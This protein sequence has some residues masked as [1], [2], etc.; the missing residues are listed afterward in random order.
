[1]ALALA[2]PTRLWLGGVISRQR[3][4]PLIT[5]LVQRVRAC[6]AT[7]AILVC[8]DG[9]ASYVTAFLKVFRQPIHTG[10]RGVRAWS[11]RRLPVRPGRQACG[12]AARHRGHPPGPARHPG[13]HRG[14]PDGDRHRHRHQHRLHRAAQRHLPRPPRAAH[15]TGSGD[16]PHRGGPHRRHVAGRHRLQ[17]LLAPRQPAP[18]RSR[19][20]SSEVAPPHPS[21]GGRAHRPPLDPGRA[22]PIP[23]PLTSL[24]PTQTTRPSAQ[25]SA[26][27]SSGM[28]TVPWGATVQR[29]RR[30]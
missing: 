15:P 1:M 30:I 17:L 6:A 29:G 22:P 8:V 24:D 14:G 2:V 11:C 27:W 4:L 12:Q 26:S 19:P 10:R 25:T 21:H 28:T 7:P 20:R 9:L 5:R 3:D 13:R 23:D 16:R 18:A